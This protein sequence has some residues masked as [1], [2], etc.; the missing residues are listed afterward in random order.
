MYINLEFFHTLEA[1][2]DVLYNIDWNEVAIPDLHRTLQTRSDIRID[3]PTT[4]EDVERVIGRLGVSTPDNRDTFCHMTHADVYSMI[5][6]II[7]KSGRCFAK[8][9][10]LHAY[11]N[12]NVYSTRLATYLHLNLSKSA[13]C[14]GKNRRSWTWLA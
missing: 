8:I 9:L 7:I 10:Q 13:K 12:R 5:F 1:A 4:V 2:F 11:L 3:S 6:D 14:T